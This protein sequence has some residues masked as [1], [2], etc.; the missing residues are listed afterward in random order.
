MGH[1]IVHELKSRGIII[2]SPSA[3]GLAE[4]AP[5]PTRTWPLLSTQRK[6]MG[7]PRKLRV[8]SQWSAL[9]D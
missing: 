6:R 2:R 4:E 9:R 3:C 7:S 1:Q 8:W 5:A